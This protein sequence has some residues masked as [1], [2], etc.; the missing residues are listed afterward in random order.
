MVL[1]GVF[2]MVLVYEVKVRQERTLWGNFNNKTTFEILKK[3]FERR[4][5]FQELFYVLSVMFTFRANKR[6]RQSKKVFFCSSLSVGRA[7]LRFRSSRQTLFLLPRRCY[8]YFLTFLFA[9][10][11][12][13]LN[14]VKK[15]TAP[16]LFGGCFLLRV[17]GFFW[18][19]PLGFIFITLLGG[20]VFRKK[21]HH[22]PRTRA[23]TF[24]SFLLKVPSPRHTN[25]AAT[26]PPVHKKKKQ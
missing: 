11:R 20:G 5:K 16:C 24:S 8:F 19:A 21:K 13:A 14:K 17:F 18:Y 3:L 9:S 6:S 2:I 1:V 7:S 26:P 25:I 22:K 4:K 15:Q 10:L 23:F 12:Y